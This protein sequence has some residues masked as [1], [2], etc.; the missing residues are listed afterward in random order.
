MRGGDAP[1]HKTSM[2]GIGAAFALLECP[3]CAVVTP[4]LTH[5]WNSRD[6]Q[7][8]LITSGGRA[9]GLSAIGA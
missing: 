2:S 5:E 1:G 3:T 4:H 9:T 6:D 8:S 7:G